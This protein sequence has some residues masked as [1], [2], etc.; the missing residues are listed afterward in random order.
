MIGVKKST[1]PSVPSPALNFQDRQPSF[2]AC[3]LLFC[4]IFTAAG[5]SHVA[6]VSV[7]TRASGSWIR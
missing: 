7:D 5:V 1:V 4:I 3:N 6:L 2:F